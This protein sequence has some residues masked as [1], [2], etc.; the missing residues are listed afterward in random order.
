MYSFHFTAMAGLVSQSTWPDSSMLALSTIPIR[1]VVPI[2]HASPIPIHLFTLLC[3]FR[4]NHEFVHELCDCRTS[5]KTC[6]QTNI[7]VG[8]YKCHRS[9]GGVNT[10]IFVLLPILVCIYPI[11][12]VWKWR[13]Q[14]SKIEVVVVFRVN[15]KKI[16][17]S[18]LVLW[19]STSNIFKGPLFCKAAVVAR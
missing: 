17:S 14:R 18:A 11:L 4:S 15:Q 5:V 8:S 9:N 19:H 2:H 3:R 7:A 1:R 12:P 6:H 13:R 10:V 16:D